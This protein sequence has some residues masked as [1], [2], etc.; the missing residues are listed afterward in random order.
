VK[1][2]DVFGGKVMRRKSLFTSLRVRAD[3]SDIR[4]LVP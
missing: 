4:D 1:V 3:V 2:I